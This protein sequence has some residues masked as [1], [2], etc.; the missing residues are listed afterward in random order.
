MEAGFAASGQL[1]FAHSS[2][3]RPLGLGSCSAQAT[4]QAVSPHPHLSMQ[5]WPVAQEGSERHAVTCAAQCVSMHSQVVWQEV[6]LQS[7]I[8]DTFDFF[9]G[10]SSVRTPSMSDPAAA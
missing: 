8:A 5:L 10:T 4:A 3:A 1:P 9:C 2:T 6:V 7:G